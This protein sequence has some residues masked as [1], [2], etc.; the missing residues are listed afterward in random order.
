MMRFVPM[1]LILPA[2]SGGLTAFNV[3]GLQI[4]ADDAAVQI[5]R[6]EPA[7]GKPK[8]GDE[9][10]LRGMGFTEGIEV[11]FDN[12]RAEFTRLDERTL[13]VTTPKHGS[14]GVVDVTV[15]TDDGEAIL[16]D[17]FSYTK[18]ATTSNDDDDDDS[19]EIADSTGMTGGLV[20]FNFL[21][22]PCAAC[23]TL[24]NNEVMD[25]V[26]FFHEPMADSWFDDDVPLN[27]CKVDYE[28]TGLDPAPL[29]AGNNVTLSSGSK[30]FSLSRDGDVYAATAYNDNALAPNAWY[31][32]SANAGS[33]LDAVDVSAVVKAPS[34][35][36]VSQPYGLL[37]SSQAYAFSADIST[38]GQSF[39]WTGSSTGVMEIYLGIY[40]EDGSSYLGDISCRVDDTGSFYIP[41]STFNSFPI[42]GLVAVQLSRA[43]TADETLSNNGSTIESVGRVGVLG[44]AS[45]G[46]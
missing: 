23:F 17:G 34:A 8:G 4:T 21:D 29:Y 22:V 19:D 13:L 5:H 33:D 26:V 28:G 7:E 41:S 3:D 25:A 32:L 10:T 36:T 14:E 1:F 12:D 42:Y 31:D 15:I 18:G 9:V 45:L 20:S 30:S 35:F 43:L 44:T 27:S 37:E 2:C 38:S 40:T 11:F 24:S 46:W 16:E 6:L 39:S